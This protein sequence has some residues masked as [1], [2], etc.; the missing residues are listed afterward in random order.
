MAKF[1][2]QREKERE[3]NI[4]RES[5]LSVHRCQSSEPLIF[6]KQKLVTQTRI[7]TSPCRILFLSFESKRKAFAEFFLGFIMVSNVSNNA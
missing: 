3:K 7:R 4:Y 6:C 5:I 1:N 2:R